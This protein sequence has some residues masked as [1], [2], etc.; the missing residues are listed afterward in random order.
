MGQYEAK[1]RIEG[2]EDPPITV[3]VDLTGDRMVV[4][5]GE[6]EVGD[7]ARKEI[8]VAAQ[9]DGFHIRAEGEEMVLDIRDDAHFAV[10]L[11]MRQAHPFLRRKIAALLRD[12]EMAARAAQD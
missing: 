1:L 6:I 7:W 12:Q 11:G 9:L 3:V 2:T 4:K 5:A 10:E 8:R